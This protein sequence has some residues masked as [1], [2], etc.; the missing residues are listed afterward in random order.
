MMMVG[1][2]TD[3]ANARMISTEQGKSYAQKNGISFM[4]ASA[5]SGSQVEASFL[6]VCH[7]WQATLHAW[8]ERLG[9][10]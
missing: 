3:L 6:Q 9:P 5:L 2:K 4:E 10:R 1:N 8:P 7:A